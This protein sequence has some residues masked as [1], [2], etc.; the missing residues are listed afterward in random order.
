[1]KLAQTLSPEN[2]KQ[3]LYMNKNNEMNVVVYENDEIIWLTCDD[4]VQSAITKQ[5]PYRSVLPHNY[6]MLL[7]LLHDEEPKEVLE[8]GAGALSIQRYLKTS[9]PNI[10]M[11]SV[12]LNDVILEVC[13]RCFPIYEQLNVVQANAFDYIDTLQKEQYDWLI[14]DLFYGADSP[15]HQTPKS[16]I[17]KLVP[18]I[19][20]KGW[21]IINVL[22]KDKAKL[23]ELNLILR[24]ITTGKVY[25]YAVPDMQNHIFFVKFDSHFSFPGEIEQHN[26]A[27]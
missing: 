4:I 26:L 5:P 12:E 17:S 24:E 3:I 15:I 8:L 13:E 7:P 19:K 18:A 2:S 1:M 6:V 23:E 25:L 22:T 11:L 27:F 9:H 21:L 10:R 16:F 20:D 14:V